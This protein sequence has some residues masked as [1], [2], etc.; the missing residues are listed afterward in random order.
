[1]MLTFHRR[2]TPGCSYP[3]STIA[4]CF[5]TPL[6][7]CSKHIISFAIWTLPLL[8]RQHPSVGKGGDKY[9]KKNPKQQP[10][11]QQ[12]LDFTQTVAT[13][14]EVPEEMAEWAWIRQRV[15]WEWTSPPALPFMT[16]QGHSRGKTKFAGLLLPS[17][18]CIERET[19]SR[20]SIMKGP[21]QSCWVNHISGCSSVSLSA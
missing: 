14:A 18:L 19:C 2:L 16:G 15:Q 1:M 21:W 10:K 12:L 3:N 11:K 7:L 4:P 6:L 9:W 8:E 20:C 17:G 5:T 13:F